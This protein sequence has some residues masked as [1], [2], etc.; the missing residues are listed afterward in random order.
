MATYIGIDVGKKELQIYCPSLN[1]SWKILNNS[2][3]LNSLQG[4]LLKHYKT[5]ADLVIVFEPTGGY[6][7]GL[8]SFLEQHDIPFAMAHPNKVR[9]F[10][11][12]KGL[13]AK[14]DKMDSKLIHDYAMQFAID[15]KPCK[16]SEG[17]RTLK[18]LIQ[19]RQ[20]LILSKNQEIARLDHEHNP[21]MKAS[22][23]N[24]LAYLTKELEDINRLILNICQEDSQIRGR[25]QQ[26]TSIPG[27]GIV[28]ATTVICE[29]VEL[30]QIDFRK[31]TALVG[32]APFAR[33]SGSYKGK[34]HIYA[35][36]SNLRKI[37]YMAA[38]A[39]LRANKRLKEFYDKLVANHKPPKVALIA[40]MRKLLGF[41]HAL[42]KNNT[43]WQ[44]AL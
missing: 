10:A 7:Y 11:R 9:S 18:A 5:F 25:I 17:Q 40:V 15:T 3:G 37:L 8:R 12:A 27:V 33:E 26:L 21:M 31:V 23:K 41:M 34:R 39:S 2:K 6:E 29:C 44:P 28:L 4:H 14:T 35:G 36:R 19:R 20:Q 38:V 42:L 1:R 13:L 24:H 30:G 32:L 22:L 43:Y 16:V